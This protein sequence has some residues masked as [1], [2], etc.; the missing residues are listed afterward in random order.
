MTS[1]IVLAIVLAAFGRTVAGQAACPRS[2]GSG[3]VAVSRATTSSA[4][5]VNAT[6]LRCGKRP[7]EAGHDRAL[8]VSASHTDQLSLLV[9]S[10]RELPFVLRS[11]EVAVRV[12]DEAIAIK[13]PQLS[14][15]DSNALSATTRSGVRSR[16]RP[17]ECSAVGL[18]DQIIHGHFHIR[19]RA[20]ESPSDIGN[21]L[22][23]HGRRGTVD[24]QQT[25]LYYCGRLNSPP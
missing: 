5:I 15:A 8:V 24:A 10:E 16:Q 2:G 3:E 12:R 23:P 9:E 22:A 6:V 17:V 18:T 14:S 19:K 11:V 20:H 13:L 4:N 1:R 7:D 21:G 25:V